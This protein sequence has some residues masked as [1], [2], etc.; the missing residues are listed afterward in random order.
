MYG[1][2]GEDIVKIV[3]L[4]GGLSG[5][6]MA[7]R[8]LRDHPEA[9][10]KIIG[11]GKGTIH[12]FHLHRPIDLPGLDNLKPEKFRV[13]VWDGKE[14][15]DSPSIRDV[16]R[17]AL[18]AFGHLQ[19]TNIN[20]A[21][22]QEIYPVSKDQA[23]AVL[24]KDLDPDIFIEGKVYSI[25]REVKEVYLEEPDGQVNHVNYDYLISTIPLPDLCN[26]AGVDFAKNGI[27]FESFPFYTGMADLG[28]STNLY[29]MLY[30][31][32][33]GN[34]TRV[35]LLDDKIF[36]EGELGHFGS[37]DNFILDTY[38]GAD[39]PID[40]PILKEIK[41]GRIRP[42]PANKRKPLLHWLTEEHNIFCLGRFG[43]WNFKVTN[44]VWDDTAFISSLLYAKS[45][46][47]KWQL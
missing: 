47:S 7:Q 46:A 24:H 21:D 8:L 19:V 20:N 29:Q 37:H 42:L 23:M 43:C 33:F 18:K 9:E 44:D 12:P 32:G 22:H 13:Q 16:N 4:G 14:F 41:P 3:I 40:L 15:K 27:E 30:C 34:I 45:Q 11:D 35:T 39:G 31:S 17:Y 26:M 1:N 28:Y 2:N 25:D 38:R 6:L 36:F 5:L 10:I